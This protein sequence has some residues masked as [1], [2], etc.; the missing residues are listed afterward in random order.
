[1]FLIDKPCLAKPDQTNQINQINQTNDLN[2]LNDNN[3]LNDNNN[4]ESK[5]DFHYLC[6]LIENI[7]PR[8]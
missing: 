6:V 4:Q 7:D 3:A 2:H 1:M 8:H 5:V